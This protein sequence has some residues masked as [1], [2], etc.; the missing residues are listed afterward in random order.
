MAPN[1]FRIQ[2]Y[3]HSKHHQISMK[4]SMMRWLKQSI[5]SNLCMLVFQCP[6]FF[7]RY[8]RWLHYPTWHR[9]QYVLIKNVLT[10]WSYMVQ[11]LLLRL[12]VMDRWWNPIL[13]SYHNRLIIFPTR[14][15]PILI[16]YLLRLSGRLRI[17]RDLCSYQLTFWFYLSTNQRFPFQLCSDL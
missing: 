10:R 5:C 6:S 13:I 9:H 7:C 8:H 12:M 3:R 1:L 14:V 2:W 11:R 4:L 16:R 15:I 17:L